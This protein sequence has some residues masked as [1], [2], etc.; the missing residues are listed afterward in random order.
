MYSKQ[1][2]SSLKRLEIF[3]LP[4]PFCITDI[5][6]MA[7]NTLNNTKKHPFYGLMLC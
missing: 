3:L 1:K 5:D 7:F 4:P 6:T 2:I